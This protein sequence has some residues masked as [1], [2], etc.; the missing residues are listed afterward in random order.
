MSIIWLSMKAGMVQPFIDG[1]GFVRIWLSIRPGMV[2][3][4]I[5]GAGFVK[6]TLGLG[7]SKGSE[8]QIKGEEKQR[9]IDY[10]PC[11]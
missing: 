7:R 2:Q 10:D 5:P 1:A 11:G 8:E 4:F 6:R 9:N 3:T